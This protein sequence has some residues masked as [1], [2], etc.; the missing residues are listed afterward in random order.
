MLHVLGLTCYFVWLKV[1]LLLY[2]SA[3][4]VSTAIW[5]TCWLWHPRKG[6][7]AWNELF[8]MQHAIPGNPWEHADFLLPPMGAYQHLKFVTKAIRRRCVVIEFSTPW[9]PSPS[10]TTTTTRRRALAVA[11]IRLPNRLITPVSTRGPV[12]P[13]L[14]SSGPQLWLEPFA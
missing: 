1:V 13:R 7:T 4:P 11:A 6:A 12:A 2:L 14:P 10:S 5:S 8:P 9:Q 3:A